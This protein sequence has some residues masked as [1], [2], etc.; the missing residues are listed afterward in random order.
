[1]KS[2]IPTPVPLAGWPL[3]IPAPVPARNP[4]PPTIPNPLEWAAA[5]LRLTPDPVQSEI[6]LSPAPRLLLNCARQWGKTTICAAKAL[7][8][9]LHHPASITLVAAP[10]LRQSTLFL[11]KI[12]AFLLSLHLQPRPVPNLDRS[13]LLPNQSQIVSLPGRADSVRGF[14]AHLLI[15][16]EAA[17]IP[18]PLFEA[19]SP[20]LASTNGPLWLLSTPNGLDNIFHA[21]WHDDLLPWTRFRIPATEC[22][23]YDPAFLDAQRLLLGDHAFRQEFLCEFTQDPNALFPLELIDSALDPSLHSIF[24]TKPL[25]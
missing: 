15:L 14:T 16:D 17:R 13:L 24:G 22:P 9:A 7:H 20:T 18:N 8:F 2:A 25:L 6:L 19:L 12:A 21:F 3:S 23:R 5:R 4:T 11:R 1:M 10:T